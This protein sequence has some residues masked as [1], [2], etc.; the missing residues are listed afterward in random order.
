MISVAH[1]ALDDT[2]HAESFSLDW[3][4]DKASVLI[5]EATVLNKADLCTDIK[6]FFDLGISA[7]KNTT[8]SIDAHLH[9]YTL[10]DGKQ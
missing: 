4:F 1:H 8:W 6:R 7:V 3:E 2:F 5:A 9:M 10:P